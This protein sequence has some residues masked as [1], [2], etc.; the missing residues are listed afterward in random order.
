MKLDGAPVANTFNLEGTLADTYLTADTAI[1]RKITPLRGFKFIND[2]VIDGTGNSHVSSRGIRVEYSEGEYIDS[3][4]LVSNSAGAGIYMLYTYGGT[5]GVWNTYRCGSADESD[6]QVWG[7]AQWTRLKQHSRESTGFGPQDIGVSHYNGGDALVEKATGR[8]WKTNRAR[9]FV[10]GTINVDDS[11]AL[12]NGVNFTLA[13]AHGVVAAVLVNGEQNFGVAFFDAGTIDT[14][15]I[16]IGVLRA[17]GC[18]VDLLCAANTYNITVGV[19]EIK[20]MQDDGNNNSIGGRFAG[21]VLANADNTIA[22]TTV[23]SHLIVGSAAL[24][25]GIVSEPVSVTAISWP[26]SVSAALVIGTVSA[27]A[28]SALSSATGC[29][30]TASTPTTA[31]SATRRW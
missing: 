11:G 10:Y 16:S 12:S 13:S 15:D 26:V 6:Q 29:A 21:H 3:K 27:T 20:T 19:A 18:T 4:G 23:F 7:C 9:H 22:E 17:S 28:A 8:G 1:A 31:A 5:W 25:I 2:G 30:C 24:S 14:H